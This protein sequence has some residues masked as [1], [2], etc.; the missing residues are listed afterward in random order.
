[1]NVLNA[2][3]T[4][5]SPFL[6]D[7]R[8]SE[9]PK[10]VDTQILRLRDDLQLSH[11]SMTPTRTDLSITSRS[12]TGKLYIALYTCSFNVV[13]NDRMLKIILYYRRLEL[14]SFDMK[15]KLLMLCMIIVAN[16]S[17]TVKYDFCVKFFT[18]LGIGLIN[19]L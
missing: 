17:E 15:F 10:D 4:S 3:A 5:I 2:N 16:I 14:S 8:F 11:A 6:H 19:T 7:V 9:T 13:I 1:M 12:V 18:V